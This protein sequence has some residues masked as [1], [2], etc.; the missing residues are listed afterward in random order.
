MSEKKT[1]NSVSFEA[2]SSLNAPVS[3]WKGIPFGLQHVMAMFVANLAP[4]FIVASA[5]KMTPAQ[6]AT[7]IQAV[8]LVVSII[9][10]VLTGPLARLTARPTDTEDYIWAT[11]TDPTP[12]PDAMA[13]LRA[14]YPNAMR[15][16][17]LP[18]GEVAHPLDMTQA[19]RGKPFVELFQDFFTKMNGRPLTVEET[20]AVKRLREEAS[21]SE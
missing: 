12:L 7:I 1:K 11:L 5:A 14:A 4:I 20:V 21:K 9:T 19:V 6:S 17:Y 13:Q 2:L 15:L 16:D 3:F 10:T 8:Y 18:Q